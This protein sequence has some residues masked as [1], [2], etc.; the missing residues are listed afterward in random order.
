MRLPPPNW[1]FLKID[2][3]ERTIFGD[4]KNVTGALP[5]SPRPVSR[6]KAATLK[7]LP[8]PPGVGSQLSPPEHMG[9]PLILGRTPPSPPVKSKLSVVDVVAPDQSPLTHAV[10]PESCQPSS[11]PRVIAWFHIRLPLGTSHV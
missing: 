1:K 8:V 6:L 10:S 2:I 3:F 11:S 5:M 4:L 9:S 7:K